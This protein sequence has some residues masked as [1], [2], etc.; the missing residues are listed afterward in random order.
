MVIL[1]S[2]ISYFTMS[3]FNFKTK[4]NYKIKIENIKEFLL[5]KFEYNQELSLTCIENENLDCFVFLDKNYNE[6]IKL[7][8]LFQEVPQVYNYDKELTNIEFQDIELDDIS[9]RPFFQL[10]LNGD[11]KHK[12]IVVD[13]L[14]DKVYVFKS[15][16]KY[17]LIYET[18]NEVQNTFLDYELK[19]KDA[20]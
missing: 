18:T 15:I 2:S 16:S 13:T 20:L 12:N 4:E 17:A 10:V 14:D 6:N 7:E 9:Y 19:V 8:N 1:L 5:K 11:K 3:S